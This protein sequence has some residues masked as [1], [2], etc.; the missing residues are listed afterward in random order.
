MSSEHTTRRQRNPNSHS[1]TIHYS[2]FTI[3]ARTRAFTL[4]ELLVVVAIICILAGLLLPA[5]HKSREKARQTDCTNNLRQFAVAIAIYRQEHDFLDPP[6]L[7]TMYGRYIPTKKVYVC[8]SDKSKGAQGSKPDDPDQGLGHQFPETNDTSGNNG[9]THCSYLYEFCGASCTSWD[10]AGY[11]GP[12]GLTNGAS[13][14]EVKN[15]QLKHGDTVH[16][17]PYNETIFPLIRCFQHWKENRFKVPYVDPD[18]GAQDP[19]NPQLMG[20]TLN[21]AYGGN[22]FRAPVYW[23][24]PIL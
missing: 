7:S 21:I 4:I 9:I 12:N 20:M 13:W 17:K 15:W 24:L 5:V 16:P 10:W 23:E 6:W 11:L 18:T 8:K 3:H 22:F 1:A 2:P 14:G 19:S